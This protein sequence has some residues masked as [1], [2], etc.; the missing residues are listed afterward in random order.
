MH[1]PFA[2]PYVAAAAKAFD[3]RRAKT[4]V[5]ADRSERIWHSGPIQRD[6]FVG[7]D[8]GGQGQ[9]SFREVRL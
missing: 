3:N 1:T 7:T 4:Q 8:S 5:S 9:E 6:H 2:R